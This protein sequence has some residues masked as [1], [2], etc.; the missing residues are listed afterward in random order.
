MFVSM[1][2][3]VPL[4]GSENRLLDEC[5]SRIAAGDR[6][7]LAELYNRTRAAVYGL[8]LSIC[9]NVQDAEDALQEVYIRVWQTAEGYTTQGKP[10]AWLITIA[11]NLALMQLRRRAKTIAVAPEDWQG[12]FAGQ[13]ELQLDDRLTLEALLGVLSDE[14][15]QIVVLHAVAGLKHRESARLLSLP[16]PTVLSKYNRALKKLKQAWKEDA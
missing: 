9:K 15:R 7:A 1:L 12:A 2:E 3:P 11:R 4:S 13:T 5:L 14:E 6:Q 10:M 16:L 8:V